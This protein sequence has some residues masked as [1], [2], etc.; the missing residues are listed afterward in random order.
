VSAVA[1]SSLVQRLP[2]DAPVA[3]LPVR[4][5]TRFRRTRHARRAL[6]LLVRIYPDQIHQDSHDPRLTADEETWGEHFWQARQDA[7]GDSEAEAAAWRQLAARFGAPRAAWIAR[8][9][10]PDHPLKLGSRQTSWAAASQARLLPDRFAVIGYSAAGGRLFEQ[11]GGPLAAPLNTG[12][13]PTEAAKE[14]DGLE[15]DPG[16]LWMTDFAEAEKAGM[17][18]VVPIPPRM[19]WPLARLVVLGVRDGRDPGDEAAALDALLVAHRHTDGLSLLAPGTPTNNSEDARSGHDPRADAFAGGELLTSDPT[20]V[21]PAATSD[22]GRLAAALGL[23]A[24]A[25]LDVPGSHGREHAT[26]GSMQRA[27][28]PALGGYFLEHLLDGATSEQERAE[29]REFFTAHVRARGPYA[30][31]RVGSQPYGVLPVSA[32]ELWSDRGS[33]LVSPRGLRVL[34]GAWGMWAD[35]VVRVP[36]VGAGRN[37]DS[38][39]LGVLGMDATSQGAAARPMYGPAFLDNAYRYVWGP[40]ADDRNAGRQAVQAVLARLGLPVTSRLAGSLYTG[41]DVLLRAPRVQRGGVAEDRQL[42]PNYM[43]WLSDHTFHEVLDERGAASAA[44]RPFPGD[45][46][47][48]LLYLLARHSLL[49]GYAD[50]SFRLLLQA[51]VVSAAARLPDPELVGM[52]PLHPSRTLLDWPRSDIRPGHKA[53]DE[54]ASR[55]LMTPALEELREL[56]KLSTAALERLLAETLDLHAT[57]LDAWVTALYS[58]RLEAMRAQ[59][60]S[61]LYVGGY[62]WVENLSPRQELLPAGAVGAAATNGSGGGFVH[63]PSLEHATAAAILR[64]ARRAHSDGALADAL[65]LDLSSRRVRRARKLLEGLRQGQGLS[66]LLGYRLERGLH[67]RRLDH[68]IAP[69]RAAAPLVAGKLMPAAA[70]AAAGAA[71]NVADGLALLRRHQ[72][73]QGPPLPWGTTLPVRSSAD[74]QGLEAVLG[75]IE[76]LVDAVADLLLA[77]SVFQAA[78]GVQLRSGASLDA[79]GRGEAPPPDPEVAHTFRS[80]T[81]VTHRVGWLRAPGDDPTTIPGW[82]PS[83]GRARARAAAAPEL[84]AIAAALLPDPARVRWRAGYSGEQ[85]PQPAEK[86]FDLTAAGV[87]PL[88]LV[89]IAV[90]ANAAQASELEQRLMLHARREAP[91]GTDHVTLRFERVP[92]WGSGYMSLPE[93][94]EAARAVRE[95]IT[96]SRALDGRDLA[97]PGSGAA[98]VDVA[99]LRTGSLA[100]LSAALTAAQNAL[101]AAIA[102]DDADD[103]EAALLQA[104]EVNLPWAVP[105]DGDLRSPKARMIELAQEALAA[106]GERVGDLQGV[107]SSQ[108]DADVVAAVQHVLGEA[109][110]VLLP[111]KPGWPAGSTLDRTA[112]L[113]GNDPVALPAWLERIRRVRAGVE[114]LE[115]V[116]LYAAAIVSS[117]SLAVGQLPEE[118]GDAWVALPTGS[119]APPAGGR[120]SLVFA[121]ASGVTLDSTVMG[122]L[123]DEWVELVPSPVENTAVAFHHDAPG[124]AAPQSILLAVP[125]DGR[126]RWDFDL[127]EKIALETLEL[128]KLRL[129]DLD[130]LREAGHVT[131][132]AHIAFN[133]AGDTIS[134]YMDRAARP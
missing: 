35:S 7:A 27:L 8:A 123:I 100:P 89:Y 50:A 45:D 10:H 33:S 124:A 5:E 59:G 38:A 113:T 63:A 108:E 72:G 54:V 104:A 107:S 80:G 87:S 112:Q 24:T 98:S 133:A 13:S 32:L 131:P 119:D 47:P 110:R 117:P 121:G 48:P 57:R 4:I 66:E 52:D 109:F 11:V 81:A 116:R 2:A 130:A 26:A 73:R 69:V 64:S 120:V 34:G 43:S 90:P 105:L 125:P 83:D 106:L 127:L 129:V 88:D 93:A 18:I 21:A 92:S 51:G 77:E 114:R 41:W 40:T 22:G 82:E 99:A 46:S 19:S 36:R 62:G 37:P 44:D 55:G 15:I 39:L 42:T 31:L 29:L 49:L 23:E 9:L 17:G 95:L 97:L 132:A 115:T 91:T 60:A 76:E 16:M 103:L 94:L 86:T 1:S 53:V 134:T 25:L 28:W 56:G 3:L 79:L 128:S 122:L 30:A 14:V 118:Q 102:A 74:G 78:R 85:E 126:A 61:G 65:A 84:S 75:E 101:T 20:A 67:E 111:V 96:E 68:L 71:R 70:N 58:K 6:E 12:P